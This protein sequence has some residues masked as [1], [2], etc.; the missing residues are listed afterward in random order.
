M[1]V[2]IVGSLNYAD[3]EPHRDTFESACRQIGAVLG[4]KRVE[5]VVGSSSPS[6]ADW[7]VL[8][9][10][11]TVPG[12]H[13]VWFYRPEGGDTPN[14]PSAADAKKTR[15]NVYH[16][17]LPGPWAAGRLPQ[18]QW[19]DAV[20]I[21]AGAKGAAQVGYVAMALGKPAVAIASF[22]GAAAE[23]WTQLAPFYER[24][25]RGSKAIH[26]L[27]ERWRPEY[28]EI[29]GTSLALLVRKRAFSTKVTG[30]HFGLLVL[31]LVLITTWVWLFVAPPHPLQA[32]IFGILC[33]AAFLGSALRISLRTILD[34][35]ERVSAAIVIAELS[36]SLVLAFGL[37]MFY[38]AGSF[39]FTG[40]FEPFSNDPN[41]YQRVA[42]GM[43]LI[44]IAAGW[45]LERVSRHL[46][47]AMTR[48]LDEA[49]ESP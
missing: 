38:L 40:K 34:P 31:N 20:L 5:L 22:G 48:S 37:A 2:L 36:A 18:V 21:V 3:A 27:R 42:V 10:M 26:S 11:A 19:A 16:R 6:T 28:A 24:A 47:R 13:T 43:T 32:T 29:V 1:R 4:R 14:L 41:D 33:A 17:R 7:F 9:G 49:D 39:T 15:F 12:N 30:M 46:R 25:G 8:E 44:G 35:S 23:L 45:L